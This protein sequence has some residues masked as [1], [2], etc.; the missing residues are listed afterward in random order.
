[1][2]SPVTKLLSSL[3]A[4]CAAAGP[5]SAVPEASAAELLRVAQRTADRI[6][7]CPATADDLVGEA[8]LRLLE[9]RP[10]VF[11]GEGRDRYVRQTIRNAYRDELRRK[12]R[13]R[14]L[15]GTDEDEPA[16]GLA[17]TLAPVSDEGPDE[18]LVAD[19]RDRLDARDRDVLE[20]VERGLRER[21]VAAELGRTRHDVRASL[22][23]LRR[24]AERTFSP[25]AL[26][27]GG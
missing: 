22:Q 17:A 5:A 2:A 20:L 10:D 9:R 26:A 1:M 8:T 6:S 25:P 27:P 13:L 24:A 18:V 21:D 23:R 16:G 12:R 4:V 14:R 7:T 3:A 19:F 15:D 11:Q